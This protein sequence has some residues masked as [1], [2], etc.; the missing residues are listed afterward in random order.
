[1]IDAFLI[2]LLVLSVIVIVFISC[3]RYLEQH[4]RY[5][6]APGNVHKVKVWLSSLE[7]GESV[8]GPGLR[9]HHLDT[10][11]SSRQR[12]TAISEAADTKQQTRSSDL[13]EATYLMLSWY[14]SWRLAKVISERRLSL[15]H[16]LFSTIEKLGLEQRRVASRIT[17]AI[18]RTVQASS[19]RVARSIEDARR[20]KKLSKTIGCG[21]CE[22][23]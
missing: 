21:V 17:T 9:S 18:L 19:G 20:R 1:M 22:H 4:R 7:Q 23:A 14:R 6:A 11:D 5:E 15:Y 13:R 3:T 12:L 2:L 10:N 8:L 16:L